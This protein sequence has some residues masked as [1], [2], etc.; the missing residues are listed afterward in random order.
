[1]VIIM[2][3]MNYLDRNNIAAA[4]LAGL[5]DDLNLSSVQFNVSLMFLSSLTGRSSW[6][7]ER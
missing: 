3:I 2:Y 5:E 1:M 6:M 4:R 7:K